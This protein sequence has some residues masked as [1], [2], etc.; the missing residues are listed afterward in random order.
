[1]RIR[2]WILIVLII[3]STSYAAEWPQWRGPRFNGT[4]DQTGLPDSLDPNTVV[5]KTALPGP[6]EA[7]PVICNSRVYLSGYEK[8]SK[9]LFAMCVD[10][11]NGKVLWKNTASTFDKLPG[12]NVIASP[13]PVA[14]GTGAVF[15]YSTGQMFKYDQEGNKLWQRNIADD[16]GPLKLD[17][18]YS[19]SPLLYQNRLYVSV[20]RQ[21]A[22]PKG[23]DYTGSMTS[24]LLILDPADGKT[25]FKVD[26]FTDAVGD[27]TDAYN[28]PIPVKI[29]GQWQIVLLG[30]NYLT[31]HDPVTGAEQWRYLYIKALQKWGNVAS[32]P[33]ADG[34]RIYCVYLTG[35]GAFACDLDKL[36][37]NEPP[38]VWTYDKKVAYVASPVQVNDSLYYLETKKKVL[39]CLDAKTGSERW[40]GQLDKA[41]LF[42]A[43]ITAADG[44]LYTV[45]REGTVTVVAADPNKF[46]ILNTYSFDEEP[47]DS[48]ITI[49]NGK[50]YLR[51]AQNLYCFAKKQ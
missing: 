25:L 20:L 7:T 6:G 17:W 35:T 19:S 32:T 31:G 44:K 30:G 9:T 18:S 41:D 1:M 4:S 16:Y 50:V 38:R 36:A 40:I 29:N 8:T 46:R 12:R 34:D 23:S 43:S 28:T 37:A 48:T 13:S 21:S 14:D 10:A 5:W 26:R 27:Y 33:I 2:L 15:T 3:L 24:Y 39:I 49:A 45:N 51:T 11:D 22:P 47:V 42:Y